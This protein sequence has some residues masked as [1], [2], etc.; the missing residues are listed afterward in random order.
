MSGLDTSVL[1][2]WLIDDDHRQSGRVQKVFESARDSETQLFVPD[3]VMLELEWVLRARYGFDKAS[4]LKALNAL[5]ETHELEFQTEAALERALHF[6]R[7]GTADFADCFHAGLCSS[8][9]RAP[10]LTFDEKAAKVP[11]AQLV[12]S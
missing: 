2:R 3:T 11:G 1:V 6:Y 10:L 4:I 9:D 7:Q 5:L 12:N 8:A